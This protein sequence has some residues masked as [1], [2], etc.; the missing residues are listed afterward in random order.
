MQLI[1]QKLK[2]DKV[3]W[4]VAIFLALFSILSVYSAGSSLVYSFGGNSFKLLFKH[5]LMLGLGFGMIYLI[6]KVKFKYFGPM[7]QVL[8]WV[9]VAMLLLTLMFRTEVNG[10]KRWLE[11]PII[12]QNFQTS[13]FAKVVL[14]VFVARMLNVKRTQLHSFKEGVWPILW[15]V[16]LVCALILPANFSTAA[17][18]AM[19]C[20][21]IMFIGGVPWQ[22][23][24]RS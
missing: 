13:D 20:L 17:M 3:I 12:N 5:T 1:I 4:M 23:I 14:I 21:L 16:G 11:I 6:H 2:G 7:S 15:P 24:L 9:A 18:L 19:I 10:A 22:H 8:Y